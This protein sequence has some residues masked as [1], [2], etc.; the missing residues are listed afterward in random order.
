MSKI[1]NK[2]VIKPMKKEI[3]LKYE[4]ETNVNLVSFENKRIEISF[5]DNNLFSQN[6]PDWSTGVLLKN[7]LEVIGFYF[8]DHPFFMHTISPSLTVSM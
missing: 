5:N 1:I 6:I 7:E 3:E 4:L 2:K 8:S